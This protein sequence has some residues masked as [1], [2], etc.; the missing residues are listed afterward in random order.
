MLGLRRK[1]KKRHGTSE[2]T[3]LRINSYGFSITASAKR[4]FTF[5]TECIA[6][7]RTIAYNKSADGFHE[8]ERSF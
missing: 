1:N 8:T 3:I 7:A 4:E 6:I 2:C 5:F